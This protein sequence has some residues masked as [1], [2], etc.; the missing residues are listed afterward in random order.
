MKTLISLFL[1][2]SFTLNNGLKKAV[3]PYG[4]LISKADLIVD[5]KILEIS[6]NNYNFEITEIV[7]GSASKT[8]KV[9]IWKEWECDHRIEKMTTEQRLLLFLTKTKSGTYE[10]MN[11]STGE[12]IIG[13]DNAVKSI[14]K[15]DFPKVNEVKKGIKLFLKAY[16]YIEISPSKFYDDGHFKRLISAAEIDKMMLENTFFKTTVFDIK[17]YILNK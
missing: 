12:L 2:F 9:K 5:G 16:A 1:L 17:P 11:D 8:I 15:L 13:K 10:I 14:E 7:K 3:L 4:I 6:E